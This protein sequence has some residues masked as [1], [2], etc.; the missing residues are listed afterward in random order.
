MA[1]N[2]IAVININAAHTKYIRVSDKILS[3]YEYIATECNPAEDIMD[4]MLDSETNKLL[5]IGNYE[6]LCDLF[7]H[8]LSIDVN[9]TKIKDY[10]ED[11]ITVDEE[12]KLLGSELVYA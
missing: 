2:A 1:T 11:A 6:E 10:S 5:A 4:M 3:W 12:L 8:P 7:G 9:G